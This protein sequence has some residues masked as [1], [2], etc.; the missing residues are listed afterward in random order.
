VLGALLLLA[1]ALRPLR[2]LWPFAVMFLAVKLAALPNA[3]A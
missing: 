2:P 1:P 3:L